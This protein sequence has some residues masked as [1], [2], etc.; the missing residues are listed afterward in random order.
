MKMLFKYLVYVVSF[1]IFG[2]LYAHESF[3]ILK[4][5]KSLYRKCWSISLWNS[6]FIISY[7]SLCFKRQNYHNPN[8]MLIKRI[9]YGFVGIGNYEI[10]LND[11]KKGSYILKVRIGEEV[12]ELKFIKQ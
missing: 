4:C 12:K 2:K 3:S 10:K 9:S 11:L 5:Q 1:A 7:K 6:L 8:G